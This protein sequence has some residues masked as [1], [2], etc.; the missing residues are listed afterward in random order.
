MTEELNNTDD[1]VSSSETGQVLSEVIKG[2][3]NS[4]HK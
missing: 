4:K 3:K 1:K 2:E